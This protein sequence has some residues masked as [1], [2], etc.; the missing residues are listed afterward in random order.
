MDA[1]ELS[2]I[3]IG[4]M[5]PLNEFGINEKLKCHCSKRD[6]N[7][8]RIHTCMCKQKRVTI[9]RYHQARDV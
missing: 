8:R 7:G 1:T 9:T 3:Y 4:D 5:M 2:S 6:K